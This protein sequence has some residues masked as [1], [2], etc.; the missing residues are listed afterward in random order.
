MLESAVGS[1]VCVE[2]ATLPNFVYPGDLFPSSRFYTRDLSQPEVVLTERQT[3]LPYENGLPE[4][5]PELLEKFTRQRT[6]ITSVD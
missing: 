6:L 5:D 2:L 4:P 3:M 1:A